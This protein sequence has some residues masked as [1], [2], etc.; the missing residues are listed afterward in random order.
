MIPAIVFILHVI[1]AFYAFLRRKRAGGLSEGLLAIAFIA[2]IFSVGWPIAT[3]ITK[4][5]FPPEGLSKLFDAD[6]IS[7]L[8]LTFGEV[9]FY[10]FLLKSTSI[11]KLGYSKNEKKNPA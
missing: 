10:Y 9:I 11:E 5:V 3:A 1:A 6:A 4:F 8:I 2:I 7:L